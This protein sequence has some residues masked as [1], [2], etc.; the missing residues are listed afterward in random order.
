[1]GI[2]TPRRPDWEDMAGRRTSPP[3]RVKWLGTTPI[4]SG[5]V[6][7]LRN[8]LNEN[9][10][11]LVGRDGQEIAEKTGVALLRMMEAPAAPAHQRRT[12]RR[13]PSALPVDGDGDG[14]GHGRKG[15]P[16][17]EG[18]CSVQSRNARA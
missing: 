17:E 10:S 13:K 8:P 12:P 9:L 16:K 7:Y 4:T 18:E 11:V 1:M 15:G 6:R 2:T 3:F 5:R 14:D